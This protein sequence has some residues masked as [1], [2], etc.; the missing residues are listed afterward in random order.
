M[1]RTPG[2][3]RELQRTALKALREQLGPEISHLGPA[4]GQLQAEGGVA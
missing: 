4:T 3:I 2:A 1:G